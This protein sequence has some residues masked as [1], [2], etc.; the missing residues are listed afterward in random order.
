MCTLSIHL[1]KD[2]ENM[3]REA[4]KSRKCSMSALIKRLAEE[5]LE[6]EHDIKVFEEFHKDLADGKEE[7]ISHE[8]FWK[9]L[10]FNV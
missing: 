2:E 1:N 8:E 3:W 9:G 5:R 7:L 6:E 4:S 10:G